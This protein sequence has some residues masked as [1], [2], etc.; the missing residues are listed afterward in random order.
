[1]VPLPP[2]YIHYKFSESF[3]RHNGSKIYKTTTNHFIITHLDPIC[4]LEIIGERPYRGLIHDYKFGLK[5]TSG[6]NEC[7][8]ELSNK[9]INYM[10]SKRYGIEFVKELYFPESAVESF[11]FKLG[12]KAEYNKLI[13]NVEYDLVVTTYSRSVLE[14]NG[15][16][17]IR[18]NITDIL[19]DFCVLLNLYSKSGSHESQFYLIGVRKKCF[20]E[21]MEF[22]VANDGPQMITHMDNA[23]FGDKNDKVILDLKIS[24]LER[25][26]VRT[27]QYFSSHIQNIKHELRRM[28]MDKL[29]ISYL[30]INLIKF[31]FFDEYTIM[32]K[33]EIVE[34]FVTYSKTKIQG[35]SH[36]FRIKSTESGLY[37]SVIDECVRHE[38]SK[39]ENKFIISCETGNFCLGID[40][41]KSL[42]DR[43]EN[44]LNCVLF[45]NSDRSLTKLFADVSLSEIRKSYYNLNGSLF[46]YFNGAHL[47]VYL[48]N[49][50]PEEAASN[51]QAVSSKY[52]SL[53]SIF[54]VLITIIFCLIVIIF[55]QLGQPK[56][57]ALVDSVSLRAF[58]SRE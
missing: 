18:M 40:H 53:F 6:F 19:K 2:K 24:F 49:V 52:F 13:D 56:T 14:V 5:Y 7:T 17:R 22:S 27:I 45:N 8:V 54:L 34:S 36:R 28:I 30:R 55:Y 11:S 23:C 57:Y 4:S 15:Y 12:M 37:S 29:N 38:G 42:P 9:K 26:S 50:S 58:N 35:T 41:E 21:A 48:R 43:G 10:T 3:T 33:V 39:A 44:G 51:I 25:S 20:T 47:V 32:A 31:D 16:S 46:Y 1:M